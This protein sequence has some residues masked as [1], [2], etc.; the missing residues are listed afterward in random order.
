M[1]KLHV[2]LV[3][4]EFSGRIIRYDKVRGKKN[5]FWSP[6][7]MIHNHL[8]IFTFSAEAPFVNIN[9]DLYE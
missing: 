3:S 8:S 1:Q 2:V 4:I 7:E 6:L 5:L 9:V